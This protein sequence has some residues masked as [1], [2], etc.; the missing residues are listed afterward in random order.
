MDYNVEQFF[1]K[2]MKTYVTGC[3]SI[4]NENIERL[5]FVLSLRQ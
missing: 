3:T 5:I 4:I 2:C 1:F